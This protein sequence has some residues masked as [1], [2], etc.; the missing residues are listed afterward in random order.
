MVG[1][2][3]VI[4]KSLSPKN[5]D[6]HNITQLSKV[7]EETH[8]APL[9]SI[10][11]LRR[12]KGKPMGDMQPSGQIKLKWKKNVRVSTHANI[13]MG[14]IIPEWTTEMTPPISSAIF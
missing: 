2:C 14:I 10:S 9:R 11:T 13:V 5:K 6:P 1:A 12:A 4:I 7:V 8:K 3:F